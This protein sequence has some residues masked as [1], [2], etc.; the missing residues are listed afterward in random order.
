MYFESLRTD[1]GVN[2]IHDNIMSLLK[3]KLPKHLTYHSLKHTLYVLNCAVYIAE[4]EGVS[5]NN[6]RLIK[7]A[8]LYH[9]IGFIE[10]TNPEINLK[11]TTS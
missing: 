2:K 9:D 8:G 6:L 1:K 7:V 5:E 4:K 10:R 3:S 11:I